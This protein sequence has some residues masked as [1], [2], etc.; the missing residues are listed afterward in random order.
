MDL[1]GGASGFT[2]G[3]LGWSAEEIF[4]DSRNFGDPSRS[5]FIKLQNATPDGG[6]FSFSKAHGKTVIV[7]RESKYLVILYFDTIS[8]ET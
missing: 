3:P 6:A 1:F 7:G 4:A 8:R 5:R 2:H